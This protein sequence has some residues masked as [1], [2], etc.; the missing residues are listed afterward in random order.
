MGY[1]RQ[2]MSKENGLFGQEQSQAG[3]FFYSSKRPTTFSRRELLI[4]AGATTAAALTGCISVEVSTDSGQPSVKF[5]PTLVATPTVIREPFTIPEPTATPSS[6][7]LVG[8]MNKIVEALPDSSAKDL[9]VNYGLPLFSGIKSVK[10]GD[11]DIPVIKPVIEDKV[12]TDDKF[13]GWSS[14][15]GTQFMKG[16][17]QIC[18]PKTEQDMK[19]PLPYLL[20]EAETASFV[21]QEVDI[22]DGAPLVT[23]TFTPD[24]PMSSFLAP[25]III[26]EL[27]DQNSLDKTA[28]KN[29][30]EFVLVKE[31]LAMALVHYYIGDM[32]YRM[33]ENNLPIKIE[34]TPCGPTEA[35]T[36]FLATIMKRNGRLVAMFDLASYALAF[37]AVSEMPI[38]HSLED[39]ALPWGKDIETVLP[40]IQGN[41][42]PEIVQSAFAWCLNGGKTVENF[43]H[44]GDLKLIP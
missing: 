11:I 34:T 14:Y 40:Y 23:C 3:Q 5:T 25:Q 39:Y 28:H 17:I 27:R 4:G 10:C 9:V 37:H 12:S 36:Q 7:Q 33:Q 13:G 24:S 43:I 21:S 8:Q 15:R 32:I 18:L 31:A 38:L 22:I 20:T 19:F 41:S 29:I 35:V 26:N 1:N 6:E 2:I 42:I 16:D 44:S 30:M